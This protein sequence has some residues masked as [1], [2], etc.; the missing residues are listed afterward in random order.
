MAISNEKKL[1]ASGKAKI[2]WVWR[3]M[4][5]L[6]EVEKILTAEGT[7]VGKTIA[8]SIHMEA[9]TANLALM[10][11]RAGAT[12]Y[13]TGCNPLS[14][15]DDV[16]KALAAEGVTVHARYGCS[17]EEYEQDLMDT[18]KCMPDLF[19]DDGGDLVSL[20]HGKAHPFSVNVIGGC[21]ETTTG[22]SRLVAR[23]EKGK[24][25]FP[26]L[27]VNNAACKHLFDNH[28]GTGQ[29]VWDGIMRGTNV[30]IAGKCVVVAGYG[31]C[32]SGVAK[33]A[34]GLGARVVVCEVDAVK[35]ISA[36]SDGFTVMPM[37]EAAEIGDIF[38]T[39]TGCKD[40]LT[41]EHFDRM[42]S[43]AML[44]N[45]GHFNVEINLDDLAVGAEEIRESRE[46]IH[47]YT[48]KNGKVL[49]LLGVGRLVNLVLGDGHPAEI[50]DMSF[51]VQA[52]ALKH[53]AETGRDLTPDLY[54]VPEDVDER[55][56]TIKLQSM[57][58]RIDALTREQKKYLSS[59]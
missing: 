55:I 25:E 58:M 57:G 10:L 45:A 48:Y 23:A 46:N 39:V 16:A 11:A 5:V 21:E 6:H 17:N 35:A 24:L 13:A 34:R 18:L 8:M 59:F 54:R 56:S 40:V 2:D 7:F 36:V 3:F 37:S 26:M 53:L 49:H 9:K 42:K 15:Q 43:G 14:T 27:A 33:R 31:D 41:K 28:H 29:S 20:L 4:P 50:M 52:L 30:M 38:V 44:S 19:I 1:I 51:A 22:I 32:G 12:V 47:T